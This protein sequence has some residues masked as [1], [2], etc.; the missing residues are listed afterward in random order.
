MKRRGRLGDLAAELPTGVRFDASEHHVARIALVNLINQQNQRHYHLKLHEN[1][2]FKTYIDVDACLRE[3]LDR[4]DLLRC[5]AE[6][7]V[8]PLV[9]LD[10]VEVLVGEVTFAHQ[11]RR[12]AQGHRRRD[13][14]V[15]AVQS[16]NAVGYWKNKEQENGSKLS[17]QV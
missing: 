10:R 16:M 7:L 15:N 3:D 2:F 4:R 13:L 8:L 14:H 5:V 9:P 11:H 17:P 1:D 6:E 12:T